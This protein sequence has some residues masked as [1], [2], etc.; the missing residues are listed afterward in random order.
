MILRSICAKS[1][2]FYNFLEQE[3]VRI[4][5]ISIFPQDFDIWR[6]C[7]E[8]KA[9]PTLL[10]LQ[11]FRQLAQNEHITKTAQELFISQA[12]LSRMITQLE[13]EL[14]VDLFDRIGRNIY[15]NDFGKAYL[16]DIDKMFQAL[17]H[18]QTTLEIMK[19]EHSRRVSVAM[20][21][22]SLWGYL[23]TGFQK[24][25][26]DYLIRQQEFVSDNVHE[27]L[28]ML[29]L[30]F[31]IAGIDDIPT[32]DLDYSILRRDSVSLCV[33]KNHH[34]AGRK[35]IRLIEAKDEKFIGL[36]PLMPVGRFYK[37]LCEKAGFTPKIVIECDYT[38]RPMLIKSSNYVAMTTRHTASRSFF[39]DICCIPIEDAAEER[40]TAL[41]W[42]SQRKLSQ[43][44]MDFKDY[45]LAHREP[46]ESDP[47]FEH[48]DKLY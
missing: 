13:D 21:S 27:R 47:P 32:D 2:Y 25:H 41:F 17:E 20:A 19:A 31:V 29:K 14:G 10:Q 1:L 46:T 7:R 38:I 43:A 15:L 42:L 39:G 30:D 4:N 8:E 34:F 26:P 16:K 33:S 23:I 24:N 40:V 3:S 44:A 6:I 37:R 11:Y 12:A 36:P 45:T 18:G 28:S 48:N 5:I 22:S 9:M 35:S